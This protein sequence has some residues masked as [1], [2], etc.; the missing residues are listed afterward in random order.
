MTAG[1][2]HVGGP[3][4]S[5]SFNSEIEPDGKRSEKADR[6]IRNCG[7]G[8]RC[9]EVRAGSFERCK[10]HVRTEDRRHNQVGMMESPR[11]A[12]GFSD[13]AREPQ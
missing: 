5:A 9:D 2:W 13:S 6:K 7:Q 3:V 12:G 11:I 8:R 10:C 1:S 4:I